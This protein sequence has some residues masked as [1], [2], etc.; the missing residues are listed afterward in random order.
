MKIKREANNKNHVTNQKQR[1][2]PVISRDNAIAVTKAERGGTKRKANVK[3]QI[4]KAKQFCFFWL[5]WF[6]AVAVLFTLQ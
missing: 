4:K 6:G 2:R 5:F 3:E 1:P